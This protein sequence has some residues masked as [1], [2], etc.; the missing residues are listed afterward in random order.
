MS[1]AYYYD[2]QQDCEDNEG[3]WDD[4]ECIYIELGVGELDCPNSNCESMD[5]NCESD[6]DC[7]VSYKDK[8][9]KYQSQVGITL[10]KL[11]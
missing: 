4:A 5:E 8:N 3:E 6:E 11:K 10:P 9:G 2:N 1:K 7:E